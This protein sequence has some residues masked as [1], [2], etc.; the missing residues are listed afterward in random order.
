MVVIYKWFSVCLL[1][2][3]AGAA[4]VPAQERPAGKT[5]A[6]SMDVYVFPKQGQAAAQ[7]SQDEA[8]CYQWAANQTGTDPFTLSKQAAQQQAQGQQSMEQARQTG[9]GAGVRGAARGAAAG[10]IVG[11]I[12]NDDAGRG[13]AW[14]A[15][16]GATASRRRAR[17]ARAQTV[18]KTEQE[19]QARQAATQQQIDG[20]KKA[21]AVCLEA[22]EYLVKY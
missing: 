22:K 8:A 6:A 7:Q 10:A 21:F 13:A 4:G 20:F 12:A 5:L 18:Q 16:V 11:E 15:A 3:V 9:Q 1:L 19:N 17:R 2:T 14:G